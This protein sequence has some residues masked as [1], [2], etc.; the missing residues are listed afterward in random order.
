MSF[1]IPSSYPVSFSNFNWTPVTV[2]AA[3]LLML[4]AWCVPRCGASHWYH[5]K[6]ST[7]DDA[8]MVSHPANHVPCFLITG[9]SN[10]SPLILHRLASLPY[11]CEGIQFAG[12][13]SASSPIYWIPAFRSDANARNL[14]QPVGYLHRSHVHI[15]AFSPFSSAYGPN[16]LPTSPRSY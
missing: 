2:G 4:A 1:I 10:F 12:V 13:Q 9:F 15:K 14:L 8:S 7:L 6:A 5:G 16:L 3:L 11:I